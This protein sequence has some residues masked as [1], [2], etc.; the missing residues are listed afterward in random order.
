ME[1]TMDQVRELADRYDQCGLGETSSG[2]FLRSVVQTNQM[3]RGGGV[4]WLNDLVSKGSPQSVAPLVSEIENLV[5]RSGRPDTV[6][7]LMSVLNKVKAGWKLTEHTQSELERLRKQVNDA[8]PD[9]E[10]G[11][12]S[13]H[14]L[15]GLAARK[16]FSSYSYWSARPVIS[17][18]LD[19]I[20]RRWRAESKI[21]PDDWE[22]TRENFKGPI[23]EFEGGKHPI[24]SLRW[25]RNG[26][27]ATIMEEPLFNDQGDVVIKVLAKTGVANVRVKT[28]LVRAP[29]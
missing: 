18:R 6:N 24:G 11:E 25:N 1:I 19:G 23:A 14:L 8:L 3:P 9:L 20:F 12:R 22:F 5:A 4:G 7:A 26:A 2:R 28:L 17:A 27:P 10:L 21:S 13:R 16:R 29:K 15:A